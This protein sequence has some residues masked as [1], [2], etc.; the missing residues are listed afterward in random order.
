MDGRIKVFGE[1]AF[2]YIGKTTLGYCA[3]LGILFQ[4]KFLTSNTTNNTEVWKSV[5]RFLLGTLVVWLFVKQL[6]LVGWHQGIISLY[7]NKTVVPCGG[8]AFFFCSIADSIYEHLG[9]LNRDFSKRYCVYVNTDNVYH[10]ND[11]KAESLLF[12]R[13]DD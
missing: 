6:E 12:K 3:Y 4:H 1:R 2:P 10:T 9:L 5:V 13:N 8:G 7:F 11:P